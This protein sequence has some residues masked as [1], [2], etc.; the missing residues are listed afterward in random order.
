MIYAIAAIDSER[1]LANEQGIPW[2]GL[3]PT[4]IN[5]FR[6]ETKGKT[7]IMGF[8]TYQEFEKPLPHRRNIVVTT[9]AAN[10]RPGFEL[11][12]DIKKFLKE[13]EEDVWI[14]GGAGLFASVLDSVDELDIT[15]IHRNF[16][17]TKFFPEFSRDFEKYYTSETMTENNI[18]FQFTRWKRKN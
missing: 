18:E 3:L 10:V 15:I 5:H 14:I 16:G 12:R 6:E 9:K 17:C 4:D 13:V 1:G 7:V 2:Q 8:A 11:Q